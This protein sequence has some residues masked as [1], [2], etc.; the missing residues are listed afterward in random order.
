MLTAAE[1][2]AEGEIEERKAETE[3]FRCPEAKQISS[4]RSAALAFE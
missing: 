2:D 1:S 4:S 3:A